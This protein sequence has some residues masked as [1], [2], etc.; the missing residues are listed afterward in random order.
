MEAKRMRRN[1]YNGSGSSNSN[2]EKLEL[3]TWQNLQISKCFDDNYI[4]R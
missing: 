4:N 2:S 3:K 1:E